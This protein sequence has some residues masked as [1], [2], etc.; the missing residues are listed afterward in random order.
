MSGVGEGIAVGL[1]EGLGGV[2][3][4]L[5]NRRVERIKTRDQEADALTE[6]IKSIA[7]NIQRVGGKSSPDAAPLVQQLEQTVRQHNALFPPHEAPAL[8][9]R[10]QKLMGHKPGQPRVDARSQLTPDIAMATATRPAYNTTDTYKRHENELQG[11]F[12][13]INSG[14]QQKINE[15]QNNAIIAWGQKHGLGQDQLSELTATLAGI[16]ASIMKPQADK[17]GAWTTITGQLAD[18]TPFSYQRSGFDGSI[19]AMNGGDLNPAV[20]NG[21]KVDPK[22]APK[23]K[24]AWIIRDGKPLSVMLDPQNHPIPGTENPDAVPPPSLFGRITTTDFITDDGFGNIVSIP[25]TTTSTPMGFGG[26]PGQ[27]PAAGAAPAAGAPVPFKSPGEARSAMQPPAAGTTPAP[28]PG[29][30][31]VGSHA[32]ASQKSAKTDYDKALGVVKLAEDA[33]KN[34]TALTDKNLAISLARNASG[35]FSM[36]EFD[37]MIQ[38]AGL[39]NSFEQWMNNITSGKLTDNI[40]GQLVRVAH[41]NAAA[42]EAALKAAGENGAPKTTVDD[43]DPLALGL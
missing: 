31:I 39:G 29:P 17:S 18:G 15:S 23:N 3:D 26:A 38:S 8:I 25:K 27:T 41:D 37:T 4:L 7:D 16:P 5:H 21:F 22:T 30:T 24:Q 1:G 32:T 34:P 14:V 10:L 13:T 12:A 9:G 40:R 36:A 11:E 19:K 42:A 28:R 6:Q 2:G 33:M 20:L 43:K 35:R